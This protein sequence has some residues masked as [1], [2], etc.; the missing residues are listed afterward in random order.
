M[1]NNEIFNPGKLLSAA[2]TN[3]TVLKASAGKIGFLSASNANA[4]ARY[5]KIYDKASAPTVGTDA[6]IHTFMI[7]AGSV[8]NISLPTHGIPCSVG[9]AIALTT[10]STDA[11]TTGVAANEIVVNYGIK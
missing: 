9:V 1:N 3:A 4:A 6:P 7:P 10:E 11:G 5:L 8:T 2:T